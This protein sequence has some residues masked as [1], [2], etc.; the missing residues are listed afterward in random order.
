ALVSDAIVKLQVDMAQRTG[1]RD[2]SQLPPRDSFEAPA[3]RRVALGVILGEIIRAEGVQL[4]RA[5][6]E[7]RL[8]DLA[9]SYPNPQETRRAYVQNPDAMRQIESA[10]LEDQALDVVL[11]RARITDRPMSFKELTGF[12]PGGSG[13]E[14]S[15]P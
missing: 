7:S 12:G 8:D 6:V 1:A 3:R 14:E 15:T 9:A 4:D 5:R 11:S 10:V 2:V 13:H